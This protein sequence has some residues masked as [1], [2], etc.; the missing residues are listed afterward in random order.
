M[1]AET[2]ARIRSG[3]LLGIGRPGD[4]SG[5][6]RAPLPLPFG[7]PAAII[8]HTLLAPDASQA[9]IERLCREGVEYGFA[10]VCV[11]PCWVAACRALVAQTPVGVCSVVAFPFGAARADVTADEARHAIDDGA[12]EIDMVAN[13]GALKSGRL[14]DVLRGIEAVTVVCGERRVLSKVI[15]EAALLTDEEKVIACTIAQ[16]AG[17]DYVKTSTGFARGG[18]TVS[19]VTLMRAVVG[20]GMGVKA[21]GGI[22]DLDALRAMVAAG[23]TRIG[24]SAGVRIVQQSRGST[25]TSARAGY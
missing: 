24:T 15:I 5:P 2:I 8:D 1:T 3:A 20:E 13:I 18:A 9:D 4:V 14:Q 17:A 19:D 23:A 10:S 16:A 21:A 22:R 6:R 11:N 12:S 25:L 7:D